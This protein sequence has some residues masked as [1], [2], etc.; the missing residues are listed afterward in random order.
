M[1]GLFVEVLVGKVLIFWF[2]LGILMLIGGVGLVFGMEIE[3]DGGIVGPV[4]V[5]VVWVAGGV[6]FVGLSGDSVDGL[7]G[8]WALGGV[9]GDGHERP[10]ELGLCHLGGSVFTEEGSEPAHGLGV[11]LV[12]AAF[13]D[14]ENAANFFE[15]EPLEVVEGDDE[16]FA[17]GEAVHAGGEDALHVAAF[18]FAGGVGFVIHDHFDEVDAVFTVAAAAAN[19]F[20]EGVHVGASGADEEVGDFVF[21]EF[22]CVREFADGG[23]TTEFIFQA[24]VGAVEEFELFADAARHPV[25]VAEHFEDGPAD[26]GDGVGF[27][28]DVSGGIVLI[29]GLDETDDSGA[30]EVVA[31]EAAGCVGYEATGGDFDQIAVVVNEVNTCLLVLI[32]LVFDP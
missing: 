3:N 2:L 7:R 26:E 14:A 30:H 31:V 22:H 29:N 1:L 21:G 27:E 28:F 15:G 18:D 6:D 19:D 13:G 17:L 12:D 8:V 20:I 10:P 25:F 9:D 4:L 16:A 5:T 24:L 23:G 32:D 11:E